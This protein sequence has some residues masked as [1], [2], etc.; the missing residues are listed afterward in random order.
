MFK[1]II[2]LFFITILLSACAAGGLVT[3]DTVEADTDEFDT[4]VTFRGITE[5][6]GESESF[7]ASNSRTYFIRSFLD[8]ESGEISH[9]LYISI[10]YFNDWRFYNRASLVG[11]DNPEFIE[12]AS[13]VDCSSYGCTYNEQMAVTMSD[14]YLRD[15][16]NGFKVKVSSKSGHETVIN[17]TS[18]QIVKQLQKIEAS[19]Y[20]EGG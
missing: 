3:R 14:K 7:G 6:N 1:K 12:I 20:Y 15:H 9:Q 2:P 5:T 4:S 10:D 13:D 18:N 17:V 19:Q 16:E 8:K 11:G